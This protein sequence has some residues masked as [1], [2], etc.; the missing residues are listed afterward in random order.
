MATFESL[1]PDVLP[2]VHGCSDAMAI[3]AL[4]SAAIDLCVKSEIYQQE[5]DPVTTVAKIYEYDLEPPKGTVVEKILWAVYKGDKLEPISTALLE[6][7]QPN[8]RDPSKFSTPEYFVQ[9][10][11][12]TFWLAP[13][14]NTTVVESVILRAVLKPTVSST[15]LSDEILNDNKDAIVNG[16]LFRLL[17][18]P[19]KDWTDYAAAQMY[20]MLYNEGVREAENKARSG[21]TP[22]ARNVKY[23]GYHSSPFRRRYTQYR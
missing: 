4:R 9:Q 3:S 5:L 18:T 6:K 15:T 17:R 11:Q 10:T 8:W 12:G 1:L 20:G 13:V 14:P 2:S 16:A 22:I 21:N 23:G 19:S 7:R